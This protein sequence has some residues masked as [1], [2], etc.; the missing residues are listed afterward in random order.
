MAYEEE[1]NVL[2]EFKVKIFDEVEPN[3][4]V[5]RLRV[6]KVITEGECETITS[7]VNIYV[8]NV[9]GQNGIQVYPEAD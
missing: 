4:V 7:L 8:H 5:Y 6:Q 3:D 9:V 1:T 2:E